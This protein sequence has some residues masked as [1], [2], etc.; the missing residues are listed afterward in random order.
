MSRDVHSC[1]HWLRPSNPL[2]PLDWDSYTRSLLVSKD[3]RHLN[4]TPWLYLYIDVKLTAHHLLYDGDPGD[5]E[6]DQQQDETP[7]HLL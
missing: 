3:R 4:V 5:G 6:H 2:Y 1:T 7:E